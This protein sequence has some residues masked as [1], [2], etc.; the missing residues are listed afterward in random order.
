MSDINLLKDMTEA[1]QAAGKQQARTT[2]YDTEA[3]V[4]RVEGGTAWV[5]IPGGVDET[6]VKLT[7]AA[8]AGDT[9]QIR[10]SGGAAWMV[11]NATA[12]PT[13]DTRA[14]RAE[15]AAK[16]AAGTAT[17][18]VTDTRDGI[19]VHPRDNKADGV[20]ITD[21]IEIL[22]GGISYIRAYVEDN[23][24]KVRVGRADAGHSIIDS[25]G[26]RIFGGDGT[27]ELAN[28]GYGEGIALIG[29]ETAPYYSLGMR[30]GTPGIYSMAEG[31]ECE[32]SGPHSH[33]EGTACAATKQG[34]HA[35][36][37]QSTATNV[38]AHA[39]GWVC[40][41]SGWASHAEGAE[42]SSGGYGAHAEGYKTTANPGYGAHAEG[43]ET[44][45]SGN[46]GAHAEGRGNT[47]SGDASHAGGIG[48]TAAYEAQTVIGKYASAPAS[49]DLMLIGNGSST[50]NRS[51]AMRLKSGGRVEFAGAVGSGLSWDTRTEMVN[52]A[53]G[54]QQNRPYLFAAGATW[55]NTANAGSNAAFGIICK[56]STTDWR[57]LFMAG[58]NVYK[59][60]FTWDGTGTT[61]GT[62]STTQIG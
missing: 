13:D 59:S 56:T 19:F 28:I 58:A 60:I 43:Y 26:M 7:I 25:N 24:A 41:A 11:G 61:T 33:A 10:V 48:N 38:S 20:R 37:N 5:H 3:E 9:V 62:F 46:Y 4:R 40:A 53:S 29:T 14:K 52:A 54:L 39:E 17:D 1:I 16:V 57:L 50:S 51:N 55:A 6:P 42:T 49:D 30:T 22:R 18:F 12:P 47:A 15:Q 44:T 45:A 35:E 21:A 32:A 8:K 31:R 27:E 36:G 2:A 23:L 34:G